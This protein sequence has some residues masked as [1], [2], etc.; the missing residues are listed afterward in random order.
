[1]W[2]GTNEGTIHVY[3]KHTYQNV[4]VL[5]GHTDAVY[6]LY[7]VED[8]YI[9]SG[10]GRKDSKIAI[11]SVGKLNFLLNRISYQNQVPDTVL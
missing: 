8:R 4:V 10:S 7:S 11:W 1:M 5:E 2:I 9:I 6:C 3:N